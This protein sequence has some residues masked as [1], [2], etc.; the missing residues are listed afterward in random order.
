MARTIE[1]MIIEHGI[2]NVIHGQEEAFEAAAAQAAHVIAR[3]PGFRFVRFSRGVERPSTYLLLVG[4]DSLEDHND[5]F[6][7]SDLFREW[8]AHIG[9]YFDGP[10]EVEHYA[11]AVPGVGDISGL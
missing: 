9:P 6:R 3:S 1:S 5:G 4:W 8:R 10:P 2:I 11:G 7:G